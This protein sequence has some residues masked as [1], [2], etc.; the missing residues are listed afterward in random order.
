MHKVTVY[1]YRKIMDIKNKTG[2]LLGIAIKEAKRAPM[3]LRESSN[4]TVEKGV[5]GD[6]R[7]NPGKRQ[8]T[9]VLQESWGKACVDLN[10]SLPWIGRR[11]NLLVNGIVIENS[12]G[13]YLQ[14]GELV[15]EITGETEPCHRMD[16]FYPG[17]Q[18]VLKPEWRGGVTCRVIKSG[19][20]NLNDG[21]ILKES[22]E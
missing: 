3:I 8:V 20:V 13:K 17:L 16:E 6:Y 21:V 2:K 1:F 18:E 9:V 15:L 12:T 19:S 22:I 11:A 14:I 5:E 4:V 10:K 7:G